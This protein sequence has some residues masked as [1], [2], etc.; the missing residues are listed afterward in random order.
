MQRGAEAVHKANPNVLTILSG[1]S[2]DSDLSF[3]AN[4]PVSLSYTNK[5]VFE[6]HQYAF[7]NGRVW[8]GINVDEVCG[9]MTKNLTDGAGFLVDQ[10]FPLFV[11]EWGV[12]LSYFG[13]RDKRFTN[14]FLAWMVEH[15]LDWALWALT[16]SYYLREGQVNAKEQFGI[17]DPKWTHIRNERFL[18]RISVIQYPRQG[19]EASF[20][21]KHKMI[22]HPLTG[23]CIL[24]KPGME[25]QLG[26]CSKSNHWNH[27]PEN[28]LEIK[29]SYLCLKAQGLNL[30]AKLSTSCRGEGTSWAPISDSKLHLATTL[31][32]NS[33]ACLDV[34]SQNNLI[35][36]SCKCLSEKNKCDP[37]SQ[38][39]KIADVSDLISS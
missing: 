2:Y 26:N 36:T 24:S 1:L 38:W 28:T 35:T 31:S 12:D 10:G 30:P 32:N 23:L 21:N 19:P 11:S 39:F 3:V 33:T 34:D 5:L 4:R 20:R 6:V 37:G 27:T 15:D 29:G 14:C 17:L 8:E 9:N 7:S 22:F 13:K 16:G 25:V 18:Q